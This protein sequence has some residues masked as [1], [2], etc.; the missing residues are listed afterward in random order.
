MYGATKLNCSEEITSMQ[1]YEVNTTVLF[2]TGFDD[3]EFNF[4]MFDSMKDKI[5]NDIREAF[6]EDKTLSENINGNLNFKFS[7][8]KVM[9]EYTFLCHDEN[10][11]EAESFS[12]Y[13]LRYIRDRLQEQ[14]YTI[15]KVDC[16]A[17]EMDMEWLDRL[18]EM[19]F[20]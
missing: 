4:L 18:E 7:G 3:K 8:Y 2:N 13:C 20:G 6:E 14:G 17:S 15:E 10:E 16:E 12:N 19:W 5:V 11:S 9:V 1:D